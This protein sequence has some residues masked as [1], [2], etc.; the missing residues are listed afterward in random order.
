V[1]CRDEFGS[2]TLSEIREAD[3]DD[4]KRFEPFPKGDDERLQ[5]ER[6]PLE[7]RLFAFRGYF[8]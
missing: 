8:R 3:C 7:M 4:E 5:H 1:N 2:L 6:R